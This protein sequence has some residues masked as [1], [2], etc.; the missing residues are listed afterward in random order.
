MLFG[1]V[2]DV[3]VFTLTIGVLIIGGMVL[4]RDVMKRITRRSLTGEEQDYDER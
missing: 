2:E 3:L 4:I 1:F